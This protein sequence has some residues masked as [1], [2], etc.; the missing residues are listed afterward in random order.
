LFFAFASCNLYFFEV[1]FQIRGQEI[2]HFV[3]PAKFI[4][5]LISMVFIASKQH[6][7]SFE[8]S[9]RAKGITLSWWHFCL[10]TFD[11]YAW[12]GRTTHPDFSSTTE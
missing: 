9:W 12:Q 7:S 6:T 11:V 8:Y 5:W 4:A 1:L 10:I 2:F 3:Y